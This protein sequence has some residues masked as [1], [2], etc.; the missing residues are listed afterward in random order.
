MLLCWEVVGWVEEADLVGRPPPATAASPCF[1]V[2]IPPFHAE[3]LGGIFGFC[4]FWQNAKNPAKTSAWD[5]VLAGFW[6]FGQN[7]QNSLR[8]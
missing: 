1:G 7:G 2:E 8:V 6:D 4:Q 5:G 3:V